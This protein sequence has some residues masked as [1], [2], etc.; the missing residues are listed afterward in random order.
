MSYSVASWIIGIVLVFAGIV[1]PVT[2]APFQRIR[3]RRTG[4]PLGASSNPGVYS[5][6]PQS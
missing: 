3:R 6:V 2:F 4:L 5:R 1:L